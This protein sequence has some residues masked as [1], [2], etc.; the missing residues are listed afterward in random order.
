MASVTTNRRNLFIIGF[1]IM[2]MELACIRWF[3]AY[4]VFLQFFTNVVLIAAFV[5]MSIGCMCA[6]RSEPDWLGRFP[7]LAA[8]TILLALCLFLSYGL[9][10]NMAIDVGS[11]TTAPQVVFFGTEYRDVDLA[12]F[13]IPMEIVAG[14]FFVL[15]LFMFIGPGQILGQCFRRDPERVQAYAMNIAGSLAGILSFALLSYGEMPP[16][17][18]FAISFAIIAYF[19]KE[20]QKLTRSKVGLLIVA[21]LAVWDFGHLPF[22]PP[23]SASTIWSPYYLVRY[24]G[25]DK[26]IAVNSIAHQNMVKTKT[27]APIYSLPHLLQ[28]DAGGEPFRNV[29]IIGAGSGN[30]VAAA[31]RYGAER[32]DAVE[33]DPVIARI[34]RRDHPEQPYQDARV[35]LHLNDGRNFL[36]ESTRKYDLII[37]A[38]VDS[39]ILHS[40]VSNIRLESFLFTEQAIADVKR[41]LAPGGVFMSYNA[42]RQGWIVHRIAGM[43]N[44]A[45]NSDPL[46]I[47]LPYQKEIHDT[48]PYKGIAVLI[49][50]N[51]GAIRSGFKTS[52]AF[53]LNSNPTLN[54]QTVGFGKQPPPPDAA[55]SG[56]DWL[57]IAPAS[58]IQN[59]PALRS[60]DDNWPFL[61]LHEPS[62]APLYWRAMAIMALLGLAVLYWQAPKHK[63]SMNPRMFFLGAGF[64]L[65]ES[66]AVVQLALVFGSTWFVNTMVFATIMVLILGANL[67]VLWVGRVRLSWHYGLLIAALAVNIFVPLDAFLEGGAFWRYMAP[68]I[69]VLGPVFFAGVIFAVSFRASENPDQD[70]GANIAGAVLGGFAEYLSM[71]LGFQYLLLIAVLFYGLSALGKTGKLDHALRLS[72]E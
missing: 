22:T 11:Q 28:R 52:E 41:N 66:K 30:D 63:V 39:L 44:A 16:V 20:N 12:S 10:P 45:F 50:G 56:A 62:V 19:L 6:E 24:D 60:T 68:C 3:G 8:S 46:T 51:N 25:A 1:L 14:V 40:S 15:I 65:L 2:F 26:S 54:D 70:F 36:R 37:Y 4:V 67:Y 23:T 34:G 7:A 31:L 71:L 58:L 27:E 43:L 13:V 17:V 9:F 5:G 49:A 59:G 32:I 21:A 42:M 57:R 47:F 38:L 48:L 53:W 29:L 35:H 55:A 64:L 69:M 18:W 72:K 33:I 61:Y